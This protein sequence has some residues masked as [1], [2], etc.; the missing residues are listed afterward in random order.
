M[1]AGR[2]IAAIYRAVARTSPQLEMRFLGRVLLH[3]A[4]VGAAAGLVGVLFVATL[5]LAEIALVHAT[6]FAPL[7]AAGE[8]CPDPSHGPARPWLFLVI[9]ALGAMLAGWIAARVAPETAGGGADAMI[10]A[11]HQ[12]DGAARRRTV[13][14]KFITSALTLGSGGAGGREGPTMQIGGAIG[15]LVGRALRVTARE[16]R[17]LLVS[18]VAAGI[19]AV[20][21]TPLG[22]ALLAVEVLHRDDFES[23]AI[24]PAVL[25]SVVSYSVFISLLGEGRLFAHAPSY[26]FIPSHLPLYAVL[27]VVVC[28]SGVVFVRSLGLT[29][30]LFAR[31]PGPAWLRPALG[32]LGLGVMAWPALWALGRWS[33]SEGQRFGL[34]GGGYGAAQVAIT[35]AS[36]L[37]PALEGAG[38]L[39]VLA[40]LKL[41]ATSLTV[42]SGGSAGDFGPSLSMGALVGGACGHAAR[43]LDPSIDPGAF[44][45]VGMSTF[46]GGIAHVPLAAVVLVCELAGSYDLLLPLMLAAGIAYVANRR[47]S[48]YPSQPRTR[49]DS[50]AHRGDLTIDVLRN[51]RVGEI[52]ARERHVATLVPGAT[53]GTIEQVMAEHEEQDVFP[54]LDAG[55]RVVGMV[56]SDVLRTLAASPDVGALVVA[57][58][59]MR[60]P[61]QIRSDA[62][63]HQ[64]LI[65]MLEHGLREIV[66][67]DAAGT[68]IGLLDEA[69][70]GA[71]YH[72]A[73]EHVPRS[74]AG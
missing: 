19:A 10:E 64:A 74:Q 68:M 29:R 8:H 12:H 57:E 28:A 20:F 24:V 69:E 6:G 17:V 14:L 9:P 25:A 36:W 32:G 26:P 39:L 43:L 31:L 58:D 44:A 34:L 73:T 66:V 55:G 27:A 67:T 5:D 52:L 35:G 50:P 49:R 15:S 7:C 30:R 23:D 70:V 56:T 53:S 33:G 16:R 41:V 1:A 71:A 3:A 54:V 61:V 65:A 18:G 72:A 37:P 62:D 51:V 45:L 4:L 38:F 60:P 13:P 46:Y 22:A 40:L 2:R 59:V 11:F 21:R 63:L 42:G 47:T 48:L